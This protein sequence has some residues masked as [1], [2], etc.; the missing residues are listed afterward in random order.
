MP[1]IPLI[2][3]EIPERYRFIGNHCKTCGT[4]YFPQR[5]ICPKCRRKG[6]LED[7]KMPE[8]GKIFSFTQVHAAPQGFEHDSPYYLAIVELTNGVRLLTQ[9]VDSD[10]DKVRIGA[11]VKLVFRKIFEDGKEGIIAYG[12]KFK[13]V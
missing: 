9:V 7:K 1:S 12:Y 13:V 2:W 5:K 10:D 6:V 3:R 4:D 8:E 11:P